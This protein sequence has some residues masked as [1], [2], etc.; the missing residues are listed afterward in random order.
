[1]TDEQLKTVGTNYLQIIATADQYNVNE[2]P[3]DKITVGVG[4]NEYRIVMV[5]NLNSL[6]V[7][8]QIFEFP[9]RLIKS[10]DMYI[11]VSEYKYS[12]QQLDLTIIDTL[13][14]RYPMNRFPWEDES[15]IPTPDDDIVTPEPDPDEPTPDDPIIEPEEPEVTAASFSNGMLTMSSDSVLDS[16]I[17]RVSGILNNNNLTL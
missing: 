7:G 12:A 9:M 15:T 6:Y 14:H 13:N 10:G 8:Y 16:N 17:M 3:E 4:D 2:L 11:Y 1:M 5:S